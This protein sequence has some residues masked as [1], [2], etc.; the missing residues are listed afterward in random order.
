MCSFIVVPCQSFLHCIIRCNRHHFGES[1]SLVS[2]FFFFM[3]VFTTRSP[4]TGDISL[5]GDNPHIP[6]SSAIRPGITTLIY[7]GEARLLSGDQAEAK[8]NLLN[9]LRIARDIHSRPLM[10]ETVTA[11][12]S[13][14]KCVNPERVV[15]WLALVLSH[16]AATQ[17][18]RDRACQ[19]ISEIR[20]HPGNERTQRLQE[21]PLNQLLEE[22]AGIILE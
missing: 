3:C 15:D 17:E 6:A 18:S 4:A 20:I 12:S 13:L 16:P 5:F 7:L 22:L 19:I 8:K 2:S 10:L 9:A 21:Q 14:E 11:L 1:A